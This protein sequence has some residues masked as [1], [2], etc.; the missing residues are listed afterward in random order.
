M[1]GLAIAIVAGA[2]V[3]SVTIGWRLGDVTSAAADRLR[4]SDDANPCSPAVE[5]QPLTR[6]VSP[7]KRS[8]SSSRLRRFLY[9][10]ANDRI[11][12]YDIDRNHTLVQSISVPQLDELHGIIASPRTRR[13]FVSCGG[14]GSSAGTV[15]AFDLVTSR[16]LWAEEYRHGANSGAITP[17]GRTIYL[18]TGTRSENGRWYVVDPSSGAVTGSID[19]GRGPHNTIVSP[20]GRF[21]YLAGRA[22]PYLYVASTATN[23]VLKRI[24]PL[25]SGGR[26]FTINGRQSLSFT[27]ANRLIGF[28]VSSLSTGKVLYTLRTKG[29]TFDRAEYEPSDTPSHGIALSPDERRVYVI[30]AAN[31]YVHV[32]DVSGLPGRKP[33]ELA[34]VKL[35]RRPAEGWLQLSSDGRYLYVG[36]A[37]DV[38]DTR[39]LERV[40]NLVLLRKTRQSLEIDWRNGVPVGTSTRYALGNVR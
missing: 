21:V 14:N 39:T 4:G 31:S 20:D 24:G 8:A 11:G 27:T 9:V 13:L 15:L 23:Q 32:Y 35:S 1:T 26:P 37:G 28:Q 34:H 2:A 17:D 19:A 38:I 33:T 36:D 10:A 12:V 29:F 18:P 16:L 7:A 30:D 25:L 6:G 5:P 3:A 22:D 40:A